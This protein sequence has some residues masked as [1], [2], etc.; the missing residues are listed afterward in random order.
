MDEAQ[1]AMLAALT[2]NQSN[3]GEGGG[4][5]SKNVS[6]YRKTLD[7]SCSKDTNTVS[8]QHSGKIGTRF[9]ASISKK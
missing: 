7:N 5:G 2:G 6:E 1:D 8:V 4:S 3:T 9:T